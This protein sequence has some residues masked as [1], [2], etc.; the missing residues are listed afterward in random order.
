MSF[1]L[2]LPEI[3]EKQGWKVKIH[4]RERLEPPHVT[5]KRKAMSWR[6]GLR[7]NRFL[8]REPDPKDVPEEV[9]EAFRPFVDLLCKTWDQMY[10]ENPVVSLAPKKSKSKI[11]KRKHK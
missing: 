11:K 8:D 3:W 5:I 6:W 4:D 7:S 9:L 1:N 10:P 2:K